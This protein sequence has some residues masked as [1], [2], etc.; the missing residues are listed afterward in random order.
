[1]NAFD[2]LRQG[3][4]VSK[5]V[6]LALLVLAV[7]VRLFIGLTWRPGDIYSVQRPA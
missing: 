3:D 5:G 6:A 4:A 7:A 1:M 2:L